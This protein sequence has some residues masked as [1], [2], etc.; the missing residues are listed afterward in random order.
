MTTLD[1]LRAARQRIADPDKWIQGIYAERTDSGDLVD[2]PEFLTVGEQYA[3]YIRANVAIILTAA[4]T[5]E[6]AAKGYST[7]TQPDGEPVAA[8]NAAIERAHAEVLAALDRA[9]ETERSIE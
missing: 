8:F 4:A 2:V 9:I 7:Y 5:I 6:Y 3:N 1:I